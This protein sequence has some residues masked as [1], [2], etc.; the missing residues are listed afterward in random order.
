M[1]RIGGFH[2]VENFIQIFF[3]NIKKNKKISDIFGKID[4]KKQ[5]LGALIGPDIFKEGLQNDE[6][7][8]L[9][10]NEFD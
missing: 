1:N 2:V 6:Y 8:V 10:S 5:I 9:N 7:V 4:L 3:Q